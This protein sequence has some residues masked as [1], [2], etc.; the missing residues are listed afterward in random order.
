MD[1]L[2][3]D[4]R[5]LS[6]HLGLGSLV[7]IIETTLNRIFIAH[8]CTV[9]MLLILTIYEMVYGIAH[10]GHSSDLCPCLPTL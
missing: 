7:I 6:L 3:G 5:N 10:L 8:I 1:P 9:I 4:C 2:Y